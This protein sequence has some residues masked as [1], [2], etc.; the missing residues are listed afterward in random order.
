MVW[1]AS[2]KTYV[3]AEKAKESSSTRRSLFKSC[4]ERCSTVSVPAVA[5]A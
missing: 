2:M 1:S 4:S 3:K 5:H